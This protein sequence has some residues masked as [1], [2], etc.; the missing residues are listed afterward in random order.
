MRSFLTKNKRP[1]CK[2]GNIPQEIYFEGNIPEGY[3]ICVNPHDP[4]C[5]ID[6]DNKGEGK[7]GFDNLPSELLL[8]LQNHFS[9]NTPSGGKHVWIKYSG[10]KKLLNRTSDLFIDL[11][12]EKGYVCWYDDRDVREC[13]SLIKESSKELNEW[14]EKV[15][16]NKE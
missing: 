7:N 1:I 15:F 12:T 13:M 10:N 11:R 6:I 2:W 4:Y 5:I 14:L 9:Y 8:E 16:S 3:K